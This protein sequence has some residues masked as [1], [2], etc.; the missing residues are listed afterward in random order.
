MFKR[1][2][3]ILRRPDPVFLRLIKLMSRHWILL[4]SIIL[5]ALLAN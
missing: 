3:M 1:G 5:L 4:G 2:K